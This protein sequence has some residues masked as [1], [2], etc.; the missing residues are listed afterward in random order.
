MVSV[1][2][3]KLIEIANSTYGKLTP[4]ARKQILLSNVKDQKVL[5]IGSD[6][7]WNK[8]FVNDIWSL[9][10]SDVVL[11]GCAKLD[12]WFGF[13][14]FQLQQVIDYYKPPVVE[15]KYAPRYMVRFD[16]GRTNMRFDNG[17][18]INLANYEHNLPNINEKV[19]LLPVSVDY[20]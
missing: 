2:S 19:S 13:Y 4:Q 9:A 11:I 1:M 15:G 14:A 17:V 20:K 6:N 18:V 5:I 3:K 10:D 16:V 12:T 7:E 8:I